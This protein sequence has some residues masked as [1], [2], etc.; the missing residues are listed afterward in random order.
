[1]VFRKKEITSPL[2]QNLL[3]KKKEI[4]KK[5]GYRF[6]NKDLFISAFIH[7]SFFHENRSWLSTSYER[8]EFLG[9]SV[10]GLSMADFLFHKFSDKEEGE[11]SILHARLVEATACSSY[12]QELGL[13]DYILLG[14]GEEKIRNRGKASISADVFE[15]LVGA[16]YL[17]GGWKKTFT[18]FIKKL[19]KLLEKIVKDPLRNFKAEL[20]AFSQKNYQEH[21]LYKVEQEKGPEH[22]KEFK[23]SVS[24]GGKVW[25]KGF[26]SSK[27]MAEQDAAKK[28]LEKME[29]SGKS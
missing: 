10:W 24:F 12:L 21:P 15:A 23:V 5:I 14:K 16:I 19:H 3:E 9:D 13:Q 25:G 28:A 26:G 22:E 27:K 18:L 7:R 8:L 17:D 2:L 20:Q 29:K 1:M 11:L 4:E 6:S